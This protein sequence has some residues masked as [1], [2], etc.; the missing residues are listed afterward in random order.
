[1]RHGAQR[2]RMRG[3]QRG[4]RVH[5]Q[6]A[7]VAQERDQHAGIEDAERQHEEP[8]R[9]VAAPPQPKGEC[10]KAHGQRQGHGLHR[11]HARRV[12]PRHHQQHAAQAEQPQQRH[13]LA[14]QPRIQRCQ[15]QLPAGQLHG[16][17]QGAGNAASQQAVAPETRQARQLLHQPQRYHLIEHADAEIGQK[18]AAHRSPRAQPEHQLHANQQQVQPEVQAER[19]GLAPRMVVERQSLPQIDTGDERVARTQAHQQLV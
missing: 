12:V 13:D 16:D 18:Q 3:H 15:L 1:M 6:P 9:G 11:D 5:G 8:C 2:G 7:Q 10:E 19:E 17:R 14:Y 4:Q